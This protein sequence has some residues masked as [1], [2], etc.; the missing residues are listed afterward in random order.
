MGI[1]A[2][3]LYFFQLAKSAVGERTR[4]HN[5]LRAAVF[6]AVFLV[7]MVIDV[8]KLLLLSTDDN[9]AVDIPRIAVHCVGSA[10]LLAAG[11]YQLRR[12]M[13]ARDLRIAVSAGRSD[14]LRRLGFIVTMSVIFLFVRMVAISLFITYGWWQYPGLYF[15]YY[16]VMDAFIPWCVGTFVRSCV[17]R[18]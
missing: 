15:P 8:L 2:I 18:C 10:C 16:F 7:C 3:S 1:F 11:G 13:V 6:V 5:V 14:M 12:K 4:H 9:P 17:Q